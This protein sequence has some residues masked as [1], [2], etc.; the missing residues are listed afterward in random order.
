MWHF[1][2]EREM[3]WESASARLCIDTRGGKRF[4]VELL[5]VTLNY[6]PF[7]MR[8]LDIRARDYVMRSGDEAAF[9]AL[10]VTGIDSSFM[11]VS[12]LGHADI[13]I[14]RSE[15]ASITSPGVRLTNREILV[16]DVATKWRGNLPETTTYEPRSSLGRLRLWACRK[17][18]SFKG[19]AH[20]VTGASCPSRRVPA[21]P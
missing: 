9:A 6:N 8:A 12:R 1:E 18:R 16:M 10:L 19:L 2:F 3:T 13:D 4:E 21:R 15:T 5:G 7:E 17:A 20:A 11:E 14:V